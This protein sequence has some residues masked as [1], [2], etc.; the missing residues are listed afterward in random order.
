MEKAFLNKMT[1]LLVDSL[2]KSES[3]AAYI[4]KVIRKSYS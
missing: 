2:E 1:Q 4:R 3:D